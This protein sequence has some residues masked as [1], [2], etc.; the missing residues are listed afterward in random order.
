MPF[1][2]INGHLAMSKS[3]SAA[4]AKHIARSIVPPSSSA[5]SSLEAEADEVASVG[6]QVESNA[7]AKEAEVEAEKQKKLK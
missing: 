1:H 4:K 3:C 5:P 7:E 6:D 2:R